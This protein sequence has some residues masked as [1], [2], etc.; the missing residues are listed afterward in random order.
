MYSI[1]TLSLL[2]LLTG[3]F[4]EYIVPVI[5]AYS[6]L[7]SRQSIFLENPESSCRV[8]LADGS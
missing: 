6:V 7:L 4:L 8:C 5:C 1:G 2:S 3:T